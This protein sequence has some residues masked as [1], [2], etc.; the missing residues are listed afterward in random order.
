MR[1]PD[2]SANHGWPKRAAA[3]L[4][5]TLFAL[6]LVLAGCGGEEGPGLPEQKKT[7]YSDKVGVGLEGL[8]GRGLEFVD[9]MKTSRAWEGFDGKPV[10]VDERGW[11]KA[12]ART[13]VFDMRPTMAWAPPIDD[14]DQYQ[15]DVSG[16]YHLRFKGKAD[17]A[18]GSE[19]EGVKVEN[20]KFDEPSG[21]TTADVVVPKGKALVVL[22][23]KNTNGGVRDVRMVRPGY[24]LDTQQVFHTPLLEALK[25]F[26]VIRFMDWL[27]TNN[28]H[29]FYGDAKNT[30]EWADRRRPDDATQIDAN[31]KHGVAWEHVIALANETGKDIWINVP[32]A[33]TDDY[34]AK[35]AAQVKK[36]LNLKAKVYVEYS[37][38]VWNWG[39][40]QATYN[41]MAAEAEVKA[42]NSN[43]NNDGSTDANLWRMRRF[44][45]RTVEIGQI[46]AKEFGPGSLNNRILP[47]LSWQVVAPDQYGMILSW[48]KST[49]GEPKK[50]L[51]A[52]AGAPYFNTHKASKTASVDELLQAMRQDSDDITKA[53][54]VP[55]IETATEYG[56]KALCY[57]GG[58][59]S[60]GGDPT[61]IAHRIRAMRDP[62]MKDLVL[63]DMKDNWFDKGGDLF[64]YFTLTSAYNRYGMWGLTDDITK[65]NTPKYQA[66]NELM[67]IPNK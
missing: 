47:V 5:S 60:G 11:P 59:D 29:P 13:V 62:R 37:N 43:L 55:V 45:K 20:L 38:E 10:P 42:G 25:P 18:V 28:N 56:L 26:P 35:L 4:S 22:D 52:I 66:I 15:I 14:P 16:T 1:N 50:V 2:P 53:G 67:G 58:P 65:R 48:I 34:I 63:H 36:D 40:A 32:V 27:S 19:A 64:M 51:Y 9:V 41:K 44:G 61:N 30:T 21:T 8:G 6:P 12:D 3:L 31:G 54:R 7:P 23:F 46:F 39:F 33:A 49:Y 24:E 17:L 57:E